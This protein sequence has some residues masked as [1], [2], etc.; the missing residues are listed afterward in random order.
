MYAPVRSPERPRRAHRF[1]Q[2]PR[3]VRPSWCPTASQRHAPSVGDL[4]GRGSAGYRELPYLTRSSGCP[5]RN[6]S[7]DVASVERLDRGAHRPPRSLATSPTPTAPRLRGLRPRRQ[8]LATGRTSRLA[9]GSRSRSAGES[10]FRCQR[11]DRA[12]AG[13]RASVSSK[14]AHLDNLDVEVGENVEQ[15][16]PPA[17]HSSVAVIVAL[18]GGEKRDDLPSSSISASTAPKSRR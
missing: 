17:A 12:S 15:V 1:A 10:A 6:E 13:L 11:R 18:H 16:L 14:V 9:S 4:L 7:L 3:R 8:R 5:Q 2:P